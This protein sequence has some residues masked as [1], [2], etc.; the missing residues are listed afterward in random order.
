MP[1]KNG[2]DLLGAAEVTP[3]AP[4]AGIPEL[5]AAAEVHTTPSGLIYVDEVVGSGA[6][7]E[8]GQTVNVQYSGWLTDGT[9]FD[10][11]QFPFTLGAGGVIPGFE[12]GISTMHVG[13]KRR[14]IIPPDLAYGARGQG[15][16]PPN[17]T[18][19]FDVEVVSAQ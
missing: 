19:I 2:D 4:A 17:A 15:P 6:A 14:L 3:A 10:S 8:A 12:E 16:I 13:G 11:G 9:A 7:L 18:L 1:A 5:D